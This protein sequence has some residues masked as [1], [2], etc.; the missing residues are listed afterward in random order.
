MT[1]PTD[2]RPNSLLKITN[3]VVIS[4]DELEEKFIRSPGAGGQNVNK[5]ATAVQLRFDAKNSPAISEAVFAR[6][7]KLAG[8]RMTQ[9]GII[10][11]SASTYRTQEQNRQDARKRLVSLIKQATIQPKKRRPTKPTKA[12]K[13]RRLD[14]KS[15]RSDVKKGRSKVQ[16]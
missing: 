12:S 13:Q 11:L 7:E 15:K 9:N 8:Q 6:L 2:H 1:A 16:F 3:T 10:V 14:S 4:D 5:V